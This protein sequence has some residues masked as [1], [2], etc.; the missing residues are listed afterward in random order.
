MH[1]LTNTTAIPS[2]IGAHAY[3]PPVFSGCHSQDLSTGA[4]YPSMPKLS[5]LVV[6]RKSYLCPHAARGYRVKFQR[7]GYIAT[8][9][10]TPDIKSQKVFL[11]ENKRM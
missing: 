10:R 7:Q 1:V 6:V 3:D 4:N 5:W 8:E 9:R 11:H 2:T